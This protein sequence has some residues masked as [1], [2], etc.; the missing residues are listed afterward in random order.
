MLILPSRKNPRGCLFGERFE[1]ASMAWS[2]PLIPKLVV[3]SMKVLQPVL[4]Q[5]TNK[6]LQ[7]LMVQQSLEESLVYG[8]HHQKLLSSWGHRKQFFGDVLV[9]GILKSG[10]RCAKNTYI[11]MKP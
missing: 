1:P 3:S 10:T 2:S 6:K 9:Y 8:I 4:Q 7:K 5:K 11:R